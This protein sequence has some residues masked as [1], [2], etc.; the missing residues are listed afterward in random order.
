MSK[1]RVLGGMPIGGI[2][3]HEMMTGGARGDN[4]ASLHKKAKELMAKDKRKVKKP[5]KFYFNLASLE[6]SQAGKARR[7]RGQKSAK[8]R[9]ENLKK[10]QESALKQEAKIEQKIEAMPE[11]QKQLIRDVVQEVLKSEPSNMVADKVEEVLSKVAPEISA[12]KVEQIAVET[13]KLADKVEKIQEAAAE[14]QPEMMQPGP[15]IEEI[16]PC[17]EQRQVIMLLEEEIRKLKEDMKQTMKEQKQEQ[18][19]EELSMLAPPEMMQ[20]LQQEQEQQEQQQEQEAMGQGMRMRGGRSKKNRKPTSERHKTWSALVNRYNEGNIKPDLYCV[21]KK[22]TSIHKQL[23]EK[24]KEILVKKGLA[25]PIEVLK[26]K[27][28]AK[29]AA[30]PQGK[31]ILRKLKSAGNGRFTHFSKYN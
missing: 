18:K 17:A 2:L 23:M 7:A 22:G 20:E 5:Y 31:T 30:Q 11:Q 3:T 10:A 6:L 26:R 1:Y 29:K 12:A 19:Q 21:P 8:T 24:Y 13:E 16:D 27:P 9:K 4:L 25:K 15:V 14:V 28:T